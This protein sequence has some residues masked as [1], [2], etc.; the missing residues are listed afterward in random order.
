MKMIKN[1]SI[2]LFSLIVSLLFQP[3]NVLAQSAGPVPLSY[4]K[5]YLAINQAVDTFMTN[6]DHRQKVTNSVNIGTGLDM[7]DGARG[8]SLG[9]KTNMTNVQTQV[10][11]YKQLG[12]SSVMVAI[13]FPVC[14]QEF[15][16]EK[17]NNASALPEML[18]YYQQVVQMCHAAG[19]KVIVETHPVYPLGDTFGASAGAFSASL[20]P[21]LFQQY[22]C[23]H[24]ANVASIVRPDAIST[25]A[26]TETDLAW[27]KQS[28]YK[29]PEALGALVQLM[30]NQIV[31]ANSA[32]GT[33]IIAAAGAA[34]WTSNAQDFDNQL[35]KVNG[36]DAIDIHT[37]FAGGDDLHAAT[38]LADA[39]HAAAKQVVVSECWLSKV[40]TGFPPAMPEPGQA[41][42]SRAVASYSF[43][44]PLDEKYI[45]AFIA[46][47]KVEQPTIF[48]FDYPQLL[49]AYLNYSSAHSL[50]D[51]V[52]IED[53]LAAALKA[54]SLDEFSPVGLYLGKALK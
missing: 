21:S 23:E 37:Y 13:G 11:C 44:E 43:W 54:R 29:S 27:T 7:A 20:T 19:I 53:D 22:M 36:L 49:S 16:T 30:T 18:T 3:A 24:V 32:N 41:E 9:T 17:M 31:Q 14:C 51:A 33:N 35:Y 52:I 45:A 15:W 12:I 4:A 10:N 8:L 6:L 5:T 47:N 1:K 25:V 50:S 46:W 34:S 38:A 48:C 39:A 42:I 40:G 2:C 28:V 26:E